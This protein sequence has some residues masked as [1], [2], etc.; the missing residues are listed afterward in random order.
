MTSEVLDRH[1]RTEAGADATRQPS[2][3]DVV[4]WQNCSADSA[5]TQATETTAVEAAQV[6]SQEQNRPDAAPAAVARRKPFSMSYGGLSNADY[7]RYRMSRT[8]R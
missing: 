5:T 4:S 3:A 8:L 1:Q 6:D 7:I 2:R